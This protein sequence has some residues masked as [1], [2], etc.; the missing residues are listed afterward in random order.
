MPCPIGTLYYD[1]LKDQKYRGRLQYILRK[2]LSA[3]YYTVVLVY[4]SSTMRRQTNQRMQT[5]AKIACYKVQTTASLHIWLHTR[6]FP[7]SPSL[8]AN[9]RSITS[10]FLVGVICP[11]GLVIGPVLL[12][13]LVHSK[14]FQL[15]SA[16]FDLLW[17]LYYKAVVLYSITVWQAL[18]DSTY[19]SI[20]KPFAYYS[21]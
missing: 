12:E 8:A 19:S 20:L 4:G 9:L 13:S 5:V 6:P 17:L 18:T 16:S 3:L 14:Q 21:S 1:Q 11:V 15:L 10:Q 7:P 2:P